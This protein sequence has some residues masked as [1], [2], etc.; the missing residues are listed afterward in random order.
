MSYLGWT[1][2]Y[3]VSYKVS[4]LLREAK[5]RSGSDVIALD[6]S[7]LSKM[8]QSN[9]ISIVMIKKPFKSTSH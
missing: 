3:Q 7:C 8:K 2:P 9:K 6:V 5:T 4:I 1:S